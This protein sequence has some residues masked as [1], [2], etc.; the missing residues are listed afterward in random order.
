MMLAWAFIMLWYVPSGLLCWEFLS[1]LEIVLSMLVCIY[2]DDHLLLF[3]HSINVMFLIDNCVVT[4]SLFTSYNLK[5]IFFWYKDSYFFFFFWFIIC[6]KCLFPYLQS[7]SESHVTLLQATCCWILCFQQFKPF[8]GFWLN[9]FIYYKLKQFL[10]G[11]D[12][13]LPFCQMFLVAL[14]ICYSLFLIQLF[15]IYLFIYFFCFGIFWYQY[16]L[17]LY[18]VLYIISTGFFSMVTIKLT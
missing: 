8:Y 16:A 10:I 4:L 14:Y 12:L 11:E 17:T 18:H 1:W 2:W 3:Y 9:I 13:L 7:Q 5:Y 6:L 15:F